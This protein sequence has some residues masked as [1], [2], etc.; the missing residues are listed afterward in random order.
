MA[1]D[2]RHSHQ[3]GRPEWA[4]AGLGTLFWPLIGLVAGDHAG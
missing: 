3:L 4:P 2:S 1:A